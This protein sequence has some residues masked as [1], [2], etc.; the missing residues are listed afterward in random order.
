MYSFDH[1]LATFVSIGSATVSDDGTVIRSDPGVGVLKAGWYC[2]GPPTPA[3]SVGVCGDCKTCNGSTCVKD[4]LQDGNACTAANNQPGVCSDSNGDCIP[5]NVTIK[6]IWSDQ[7]PGI[8]VNGLPAIAGQ[9]GAGEKSAYVLLG[10]RSASTAA[11]AGELAITPDTPQARAKV[12][13]RMMK[14]GGTPEGTGSISGTTASVTTSAPSQIQDYFL[15]AGIDVNGN[16]TL[17]ANEIVST[18][19]QTYRVV[20]QASYDSSLSFLNTINAVPLIFP[21]TRNLLSAFTSSTSPAGASSGTA[22]LVINEPCLSHNVGARFS[23][24]GTATIPYYQFPASSAYADDIRNSA[25]VNALI[26]ATRDLHLP[27][28]LAYFSANPSVNAHTFGPWALV[29]SGGKVVGGSDCS[30]ADT[31]TAI[32][33]SF[34]T[35]GN[36]SD[37]YD[38]LGSADLHG[39]VTIDFVR[40]GLSGTIITDVGATLVNATVYDLYDFDY[41]A[42]APSRQAA[43]VQAGFGTLGSGGG[44]YKVIVALDGAVQRMEP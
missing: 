43:T 1:D 8:T 7:F 12:L 21:N 34:S 42:E 30:N 11:V 29:N 41:D 20:P 22:T 14:S 6:S 31:A 10:A 13:I 18:S 35:D 39:M 44:V 2:G 38:A 17:D 33:P 40:A 37:L 32:S 26:D 16:G 28:V 9:R 24:S 27:E 19:N 3:G 4:P 5:I 36:P 23:N 25:T 15:V